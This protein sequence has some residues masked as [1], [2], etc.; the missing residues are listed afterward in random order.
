MA[1]AAMLHSVPASAPP[2]PALSASMASMLASTAIRLRDLAW[3]DVPLDDPDYV[4]RGRK[5][6]RELGST[7]VLSEID[8]AHHFHLGRPAYAAIAAERAGLDHAIDLVDDGCAH[9]IAVEW[10]LVAAAAALRLLARS[11]TA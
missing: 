6:V 11:R 7:L 2:T 8:P 5:I 4:A 1:Q 3:P 9:Q 10:Q